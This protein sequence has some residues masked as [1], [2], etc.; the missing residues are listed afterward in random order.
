MN[1]NV[2]RDTLDRDSPSHYPVPEPLITPE[3]LHHPRGKACTHQ[4][5]LPSLSP[6]S[7]ESVFYLYRFA[8]YGNFIFRPFSYAS[9][10][11]L[12]NIR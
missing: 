11:F 3:L 2:F 8:Y 1:C 5:T 12:V 10:S 6:G 9:F 7:Y 4:Y